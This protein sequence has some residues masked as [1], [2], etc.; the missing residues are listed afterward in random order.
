MRIIAGTA[1]GTRLESPAGTSVRPTLD[2][3]RESLFNILG[4]SV[5]DIAFLDLFAG[6][7]AVGIEALSRGAER[8][9]FVEHTVA[10][11]ELIQR[12]LTKAKLSDYARTVRCTVPQ[13]LGV[14]GGSYEIV[15]ADPPRSFVDYQT[16][17]TSIHE[18]GLLAESG[19]FIIETPTGVQFDN[20]LGDLHLQDTRVYGDTRLTIFS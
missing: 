20:D 14:V 16:L 18:A 3:V 6:T 7:G 13:Q 12:N 5:Q 9:V 11:L 4:D 2:R 1:R 17:S 8:A 15:Y 10:H 19:R